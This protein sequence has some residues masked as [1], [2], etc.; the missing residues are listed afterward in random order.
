MK[1]VAP[2]AAAIALLGT[3]AYAQ[4]NPVPVNPSRAAQAPQ[5]RLSTLDKHFVKTVAHG[6]SFEVQSGRLA[7]KKSQDEK[8]RMI[9]TMLVK[10]HG[11]AQS[12][13]MKVAMAHDMKLP[14]AP[15][16]MQ[17]AMLRKMSRLNGDAFNKAFMKAQVDSHY[18]TIALFKKEMT[19]GTDS[20]V[21]DFAAQYQPGIETHTNHITSTASRFGVK[22]AAPGE[23]RAASAIK[24]GKAN[25]NGMKGMN[26][27]GNMN[28]SGT[29]STTNSTGT[30][31]GN[32][33]TSP[34]T[35]PGTQP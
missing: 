35:A 3:S 4:T 25:M 11:E 28:S 12:D 7:L 1:Y 8:V 24:P 23:G 18:A 5:E 17:K 13:L 19:N 16:P 27:T 20:H 6:N 26:N 29:G 30:G 15:N 10:E 9:A 31:T 14:S 22:V 2:F 21:R 34:S 32:T 33:N